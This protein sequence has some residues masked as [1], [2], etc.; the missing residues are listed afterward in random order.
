VRPDPIQDRSRFKGFSDLGP[1]LP[2]RIVPL[3][4][5]YPIVDTYQATMHQGQNLWTLNNAFTRHIQQVRPAPAF[6]AT[7]KLGKFFERAG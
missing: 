4:L 6:T 5:L 1:I 7:V 2:Q 3:R